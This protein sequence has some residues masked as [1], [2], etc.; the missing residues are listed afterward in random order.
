MSD[1]YPNFASFYAA[2]QKLP[3]GPKAEIR[4]ISQPDELLDLP[5]FYRL[6]EPFGWQDL[7]PWK[8]DSWKR[9][10]FLIHH[11]K[12]QGDNSLG[13]AL[14]LSG[15]VNEKRL[16][17]VIRSDYPADVIQ[18]RRVLKQA[19]PNLS[20]YKMAKQIWDWD[21]YRKRSLMEDFVLNQ[22]D[23]PASKD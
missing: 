4:R 11:I 12:D 5:A 15:S 17:Q 2:W 9:L 3:P 6:V 8:K 13:K 20:W 16:F 1:K 18:L 19:A 14:A 7:P 23:K 10:V 21:K 22:N